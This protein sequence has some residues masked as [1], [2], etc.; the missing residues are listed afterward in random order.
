MRCS[1]S[2]I[3][4]SHCCHDDMIHEFDYHQLIYGA[5]MFQIDPSNVDCNDA[6]HVE[7]VS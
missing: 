6:T 5:D 7:C 1:F 4:F 3:Y 2:D